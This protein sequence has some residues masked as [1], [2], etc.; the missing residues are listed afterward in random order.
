MGHT[1]NN[2]INT[3]SIFSIPKKK[4]KRNSEEADNQKAFFKWLH[5]WNKEISK[6]TFHIPNGGKR[7]IGEAQKLKAMG[8]TPGVPDVF[9]SIPAFG[10]HGL[11]IEFKSKEGKLTPSQEKMM[12][13]LAKVGYK[14][15]ECHSWEDA[16]EILEWYQKGSLEC[17]MKNN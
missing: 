5:L 13:L 11:F 3:F 15:V 12:D 7:G 16:K 6:Y 17:L 2:D 4:K 9:C 14:V 10:Y 1:S 8:V